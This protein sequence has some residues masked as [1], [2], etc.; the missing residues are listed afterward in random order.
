MARGDMKI[1]VRL[2]K[3][4]V[5]IKLVEPNGRTV[6]EHVEV[7]AHYVFDNDEDGRGL[8]FRRINEDDGRARLVAQFKPGA[9][10][11]YQE[12]Q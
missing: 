7:E 8:V 3:Y 6:Y 10:D 9:W 4:D 1:T 5:L 11:M 2:R 12:K